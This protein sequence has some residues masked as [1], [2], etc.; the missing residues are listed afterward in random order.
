MFIP[1][2]NT[3]PANGHSRLASERLILATREALT[4]QVSR[5]I[6][7]KLGNVSTL[8]RRA[9]FSS[10]NK[11][12]ENLAH[13]TVSISELTFIHNEQFIPRIIYNETRTPIKELKAEVIDPLHNWHLYLNNNTLYI[14]SLALMFPDKGLFT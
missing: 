1:C 7:I 6:E 12:R 3:S 2:R 4:Y 8:E 11:R 5:M 9:K 10:G 14:L 13:F